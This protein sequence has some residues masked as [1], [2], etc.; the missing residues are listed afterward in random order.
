[1]VGSLITRAL[2]M[3]VGYL[4]PAYKCFKCVEMNRLDTKQLTF[5]CKYWI[6]LA[7]LTV[8]ERLGD[9]FASWMPL[10]GEAKIAF[11]VYLWNPKTSGTEYIYS[12]VLRPMVAPHERDIDRHLNELTTRVLDIIFHYCQ[13]SSVYLKL[14]FMEILQ[15][16]VSHASSA[17]SEQEKDRGIINLLRHMALSLHP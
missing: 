17:G 7:V 10:Y 6:I 9:T 15:F 16:V 12:S 4:Y 1:M 3:L 13:R 2:I 5:W 11:I 14:L 8:L